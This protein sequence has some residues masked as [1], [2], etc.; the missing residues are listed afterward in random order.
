M[1]DQ[2]PVSGVFFWSLT[3]QKS[4]YHDEDDVIHIYISRFICSYLPIPKHILKESSFRNLLST[5]QV[6][7]IKI[8]DARAKRSLLQSGGTS[9]K[10]SLV[11]REMIWR[12]VEC[13]VERPNTYR[14]PRFQNEFR[15]HPPLPMNFFNFIFPL[16]L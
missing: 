12:R 2:K 16:S 8:I 13:I 7:N 5:T 6:D 10:A 11:W 14:L 4:S 3:L 1:W 9:K 15:V